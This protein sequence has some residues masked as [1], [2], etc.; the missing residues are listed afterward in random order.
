MSSAKTDFDLLAYYGVK[1]SDID[2]VPI[3]FQNASGSHAC[4]RTVTEVN[5]FILWAARAPHAYAS[6][7]VITQ[8]CMPESHGFYDASATRA[9]EAYPDQSL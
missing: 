4:V 5:S 7:I 6:T 8:A 1:V 2:S 9:I 3:G